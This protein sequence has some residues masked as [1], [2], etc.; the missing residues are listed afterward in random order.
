VKKLVC[1]VAALIIT[2]VGLAGA[3]EQGKGIDVTGSWESTVE[4]PQ[5]AMTSSATYKQTGEELTGTHVGQ[6][7]ELQLKGTVKGNAISYQITLEMGGQQLTIT[8]S[9]TVDGDTI[10]GTADFGGMGSGNWTAKRKK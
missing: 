3:Q 4:S 7:G 5:G 8:Y 1:L 9:G 2:G 10:T 6:M